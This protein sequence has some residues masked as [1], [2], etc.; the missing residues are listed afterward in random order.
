MSM[1][2]NNI[3]DFYCIFNFQ[4]FSQKWG[5]LKHKL[6]FSVQH[7]R[8]IPI[9]VILVFCEPGIFTL[10]ARSVHPQGCTCCSAEEMLWHTFWITLVDLRLIGSDIFL[11]S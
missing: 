10:L 8:M 7:P 1:K 11:V 2:S 6:A 5:I 9:K 4:L 3:F